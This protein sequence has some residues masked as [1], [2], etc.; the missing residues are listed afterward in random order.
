MN[1][2]VFIFYVIFLGH[3]LLSGHFLFHILGHLRFLFIF[4]FSPPPFSYL[5]QPPKVPVVLGR[6]HVALPEAVGGELQ[7]EQ[8][9]LLCF[10]Q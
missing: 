3:L 2:V 10:R 8:V 1:K 5:I 7:G 6:L 9:Q 4:I